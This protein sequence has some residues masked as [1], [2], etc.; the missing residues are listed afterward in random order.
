MI[1]D[2][3]DANIKHLSKLDWLFKEPIKIIRQGLTGPSINTKT[4]LQRTNYE[5]DENVDHLK[6]SFV[7]LKAELL[8]QDNPEKE[9]QQYYHRLFNLLEKVNNKFNR[10]K[11]FM[12]KNLMEKE[13]D[14]LLKTSQDTVKVFNE[15]KEKIKSLSF[16]K[17]IEEF[18]KF[19]EKG[20]IGTLEGLVRNKIES[21][22]F[23]KDGAEG[24]HLDILKQPYQ[25][26]IQPKIR[27]NTR[28]VDHIN[29]DGSLDMGGTRNT[30]KHRKR[31]SKNKKKKT[32]INRRLKKR[33]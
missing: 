29:P 27:D 23:I 20:K 31:I 4:N 25:R 18:K 19:I 17:E 1:Q 16:D 32:I 33:P 10:R 21:G 12:L 2:S 9:I 3:I 28:G 6:K 5:I 24:Y 30:K 14:I 26:S 13:Q 15:A 22:E 11:E 7:M 8:D